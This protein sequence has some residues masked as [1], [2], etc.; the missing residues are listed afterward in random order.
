MKLDVTARLDRLRLNSDYFSKDVVD[1]IPGFHCEYDY[2][3]TRNPGSKARHSG[4]RRVARYSNERTRTQFEVQYKPMQP[5]FPACTVTLIADDRTGLTR[6]EVD[7]ILESFEKWRLTM[8]EIAVDFDAGSVVNT[9]FVR[10]HLVVGKS[11]YAPNRDTG[12][13]YFGTRKSQKFGRC[14]DKENINAYRVELE[15]HS[16]WLRAHKIR[17]VNELAKLSALLPRK[18]LKFV[19]L[20]L[21]ALERQLRQAKI[22]VEPEI[23]R[24]RNISG[25][26]YFTMLRLRQRLGLRN[27]HRLLITLKTNARVERALRKWAD[28]WRREGD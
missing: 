17:E 19:R 9:N 20:D 4:Y 22:P 1:Q 5:W 28:R 3:V 25:G 12:F 14:Y 7:I 8:V 6:R 10:R 21:E 2:D 15:L 27:T 26:L 13:E 18:E 11:R 24:A 23:Q 16:A